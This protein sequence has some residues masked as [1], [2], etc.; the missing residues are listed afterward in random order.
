MDIKNTPLPVKRALKKFGQDLRDA[1]KRRRITMELAAERA[2]I[3]RA[4]L[5][6]IEK[7][8]D[9]VSLG[10]YAKILFVLGMIERLVELADPTFDILGL[11]LEADNLPKR[12]RIS[13]KEKGE[14]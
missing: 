2:A 9:G 8:D 14:E 4:T 6:K 7:G 11:G 12:V 13:R 5:T 1:R 10:A 3:S